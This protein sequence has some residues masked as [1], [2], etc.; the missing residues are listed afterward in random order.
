MPTYKKI[1]GDYTITSLNSSDNVIVNTNTFTLNGNLDVV[2]NITYIESTELLV[3]DPFIT[4][5]ANNSGTVA[6]A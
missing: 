1:D 3:D 4:V 6:N 5:A 2:G